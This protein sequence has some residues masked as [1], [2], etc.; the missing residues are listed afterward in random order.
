LE[1]G[2]FDQN[3]DS[4]RGHAVQ[5]AERLSL[6]ELYER[7]GFHRYQM[8]EHHGTPL[9][10]APS[11]SVFFSAISQRTSR[12]RFGPLVYLLPVYQP[13][14][15]I[16][17]ICMLD[18][19]SSGRYEF[20]IG[21]GASPHEL[22]YLGVDP[23]LALEMYNEAF[24]IIR[25]GLSE[26]RIHFSGK[27]WSFEDVHLSVRP[28]QK[29]SPPVWYAGASADSA[30]W[31]ARN[32]INLIC[33]GPPAGVRRITDRYRNEFAAANNVARH[34]MLGIN[35]FIVVADTDE[36]ASFLAHSA[37]ELFYANFI[38]LWDRHGGE[39]RS[40]KLPPKL[41]PLLD[42]GLAVVG[43]PERVG[44]VLQKQ[45]LDAGVNYLSGTFVFGNMSFEDASRSVNLF[46]DQIMPKLN[47][48]YA[49]VRHTFENAA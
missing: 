49:A 3:D 13:M 11:P 45:I 27:Y 7:R 17:E 31:P 6:I 43:S 10:I 30:V 14:R 26:G 1:F 32:G 19:L 20:G 18:Q 36:R 33:A 4:G 12:L 48:T 29:P 42:S 41:A 25:Q 40:F 28:F 9:S 24:E 46:A 35:R 5:L 22:R 47:D 2:V 8:S 34:P 16:E 37:W 39:P 44:S 38:K 15:L 21:R 23:D